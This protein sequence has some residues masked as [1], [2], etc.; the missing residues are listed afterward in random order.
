MNYLHLIW[1]HVA[2]ALEVGYV[3]IEIAL[4]G[5]GIAWLQLRYAKKRDATLD[6]RSQWEKLHKA[7]MEF[8]FRGEILNHPGPTS[9]YDGGEISDAHM[10]EAAHAIHMLR[11][12]LDRAPESPL[13]TQIIT[14]LNENFA[15]EKWRALNFTTEFDK[16]V[17]QVA[18][19]C[20]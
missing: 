5:A 17:R 8:R 2:Q 16:F 7:M 19:K 14:L 18:L 9:N 4:V 1:S 15:A 13:I 11:A 6:A 3:S 20:R 10:V 12:E